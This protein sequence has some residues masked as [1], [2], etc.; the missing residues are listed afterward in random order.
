MTKAAHKTL[1]GVVGSRGRG[2]RGQGVGGGR[3]QRVGEV[4]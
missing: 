3:G 1:P 2:G 4:G